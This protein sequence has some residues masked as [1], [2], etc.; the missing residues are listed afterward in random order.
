MQFEWKINLGDVVAVVG[1]LI[2]VFTMHSQNIKR[3]TELETKIEMMF[4]WFRNRVMNQQH[5]GD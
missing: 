2:T 4:D 5:S 3:I 1:V